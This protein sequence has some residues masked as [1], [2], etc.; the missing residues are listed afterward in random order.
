MTDEPNSWP[1]IIM[2]FQDY[3][4]PF[5]AEEVI[6]RMLRVVPTNLLWGLRSILLTNVQALSRKERNQATR[7]RRRSRVGEALGYY[8]QEWRG[9]PARVTILLD[10]LEKQWG[11]NW[12][13]VGFVRD[14]GLSEVFF[15]ELGHHIHQLHI[16]EYEGPE[17]VADKWSKK[18]QKKFFRHQYWYLLPVL[19]PTGRALRWG[20]RIAKRL[21]RSAT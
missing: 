4:P 8:N 1:Q 17:N 2:F 7:G 15:H 21:R 13:R 9:E 12:L 14:V 16:P 20:Q 10:N 18:F 19:I 11:R 5:D 3:A 6:R